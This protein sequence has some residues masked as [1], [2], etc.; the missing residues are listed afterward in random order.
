MVD[1][2]ACGW[3]PREGEVGQFVHEMCVA[4]VCRVIEQAAT[5][6]IRG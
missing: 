1:A 3:L 5:A 4:L 6:D 2:R